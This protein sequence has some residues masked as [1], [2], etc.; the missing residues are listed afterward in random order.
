MCSCWKNMHHKIGL[1]WIL[2][3]SSEYQILSST[4]IHCWSLPL[5]RFEMVSIITNKKT[6]FAGLVLDFS[7]KKDLLKTLKKLI[8]KMFLSRFWNLVYQIILRTKGSRFQT[9][10]AGVL[11]PADI[12]GDFDIRIIY[13]K[14]IFF[15]N[16]KGP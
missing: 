7:P 14:N 13:N 12:A 9:L 8:W 6:L 15:K 4:T 1:K 16:N 2:K 10:R 5:V 3:N 11:T